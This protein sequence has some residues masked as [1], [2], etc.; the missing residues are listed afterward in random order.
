MLLTPAKSALLA[1]LKNEDF[2]NWRTVDGRGYI[3]LRVVACADAEI[4]LSPSAGTNYG[5]TINL[6]L[7][8]EKSLIRAPVN[9]NILDTKD[10]NPLICNTGKL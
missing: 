4:I 6:G 5:Y 3:T 9:G 2:S 10:G 1:S 8:K 7:N